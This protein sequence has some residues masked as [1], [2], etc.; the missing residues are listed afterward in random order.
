[1]SAA[2]AQNV[3]TSSHMTMSSGAARSLMPCGRGSGAAKVGVGLGAGAGV[4]AGCG[5]SQDW[6][7]AVQSV[8][9]GKSGRA[10]ING[11]M[12]RRGGRRGR[13]LHGGK[14]HAWVCGLD[15]HAGSVICCAKSGSNLAFEGLA[16]P[17]VCEA[18]SSASGLGGLRV[19]EV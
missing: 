2:N 5:G 3:S 4:N 10:A 6:E 19:Y 17:R 1:M 7:R 16:M 15:M 12:Q 18:T 8:V 11:P 14:V 9:L 13:E